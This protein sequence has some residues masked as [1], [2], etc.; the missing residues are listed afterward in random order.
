MRNFENG[1]IHALLLN[2][3]SHS[4]IGGTAIEGSNREN[5]CWGGGGRL[6][7]DLPG[8]GSVTADD[9]GELEDDGDN[10]RGRR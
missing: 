6:R 5:D 7:I 10:I 8:L 3:H 2:E 9:D 1:E 4:V